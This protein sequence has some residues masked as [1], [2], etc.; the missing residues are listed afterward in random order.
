MALNKQ[1]LSSALESIFDQ[2]SPS[3][4][5]TGT[6]IAKEIATFWGDGMSILG[7]TAISAPALAAMTPGVILAF[8]GFKPSVSVTISLLTTAITTGILALVFSGGKHGV[9]GVSQAV[10]SVLKSGL[11]VALATTPNIPRKQHAKLFADAVAA[12]TATA[13]TSDIKFLYAS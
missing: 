12:F 4:A 9:G 3:G 2:D 7:G 13:I 8:E 6:D 10:D 5:I 11:E 1:K